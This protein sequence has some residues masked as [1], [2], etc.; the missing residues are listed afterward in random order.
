MYKVAKIQKVFEYFTTLY[1]YHLI[2]KRLS[3][4]YV[5]FSYFDE[6]TVLNTIAAMTEVEIFI[7]AY[8]GW[9]YICGPSCMLAC[10]FLILTSLG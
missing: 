4:I 5:V 8:F 2:T 6:L 10:F 7:G 9:K 1:R 3:D